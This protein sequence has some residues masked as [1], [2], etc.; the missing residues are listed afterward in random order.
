MR[1]QN[2]QPLEC[3]QRQ[4]TV[5]LM[6]RK[7]FLLPYLGKLF[8]LVELKPVF[9]VL[10]QLMK[11]ENKQKFVGTKW[12]L[13]CWSRKIRGRVWWHQIIKGIAGRCWIKGVHEQALTSESSVDKKKKN[14]PF[15]YFIYA[16]RFSYFFFAFLFLK[17]S[18]NMSL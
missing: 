8:F 2:Q 9:L 7:H 12:F 13:T 1:L 14:R 18:K 15:F 17:I 4:P 10:V 16:N 5:G 6:D 11:L 3:N